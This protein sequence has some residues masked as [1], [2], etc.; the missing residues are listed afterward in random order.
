MRK[1]LVIIESKGGHA[2][3]IPE[4][5]FVSV[6]FQQDDEFKGV[7]VANAAHTAY[8]LSKA[9]KLVHQ[10]ANSMKRQGGFITP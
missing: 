3:M 7:L 6:I 5:T 10:K 9:E 8:L 2:S 4:G 1:P